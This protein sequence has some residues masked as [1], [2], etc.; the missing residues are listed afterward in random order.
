MPWIT[1]ELELEILAISARQIDRRLKSTR[2]S[3][4]SRRY[5][6]T[7]PGKLLKHHIEIK[8]DHWDVHE[9]GYVEIDLVAHCG[10]N[11]TGPF[12]Y[13]LNVTDIQTGWVETRPIMGKGQIAT[14]NALQ[15]IQQALPFQLKGIDSDNGSKFINHLL[16]EYCQTHQIQ[17]TRS[18]PY[19]KDDNAH[20][21]QKLDR[22]AQNTRVLS[23][24]Y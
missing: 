16:W 20:I 1:P 11:T 18:R 15:A 5:G 24:R 22:R 10:S 21:E 3:L 23:I 4:A 17:F 9:P 14:L 12:I 7:K 19:K 6:R 8:T 2:S 13:S